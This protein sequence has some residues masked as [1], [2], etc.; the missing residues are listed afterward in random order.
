MMFIN[1]V[2]CRNAYREIFVLG[3]TKRRCFV[4]INKMCKILR[5]FLQSM[6]FFFLFPRLIKLKTKIL[7]YEPFFS[8]WHTHIIEFVI[9][10]NIVYYYCNKCAFID[11][12]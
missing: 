4:Q 1:A 6:I 5:F 10:R 7:N 2:A 12:T 3:I 11:K 9:R 8:T